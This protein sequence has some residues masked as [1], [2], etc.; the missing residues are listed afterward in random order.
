MQ[1]TQDK[2]FDEHYFEPAKAWAIKFGFEAALSMLVIYDS[3]IHSGRIF[4]FLRSRFQ[5]RP[6]AKGGAETRWIEEYVDARHY[7]LKNHRRPLLR[8]TIYRTE[9]LRREIERNNWDLSDLPIDANG[10]KVEG[11]ILQPAS[12]SARHLHL[13][14]DI[15]PFIGDSGT[16][17]VESSA[18]ETSSP[19][20]E[21]IRDQQLH[22]D[23]R[24]LGS[25]G[26][27]GLAK[28]IQRCLI[29][30]GFLDPPVDG[31]FGPLSKQ[32]LEALR[33]YGSHNDD[34]VVDHK[35]ARLLLETDPDRFCPIQA[36]NDLA[37]RIVRYMQ[38][39]DHF[40]ARLPGYVN[41][42]YL[43]GAD[44]NGNPNQDKP[45]RFNDRRMVLAL[46]NNGSPEI[47][48]NWEATTEPGRHYTYNPMNPKGAA[49]IALGQFKAWSVGWY[50]THYA[51]KQVSELTVYRDLNKDFE[52]SGD[53]RH[54]GLFGIHH[55]WGYDRPVNDIGR[56]S[57][58]CLVGRSTVE[59]NRFMSLV[60]SDPRY[61]VSR[62]YRFMTTIIEASR[63]EGEQA[64]S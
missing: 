9:S 29:G 59:H 30:I 14:S 20:L 32:A 44:R 7:W 55:H 33:E 23:V 15:V 5:E 53:K 1:R 57:A 48:G 16:A 46:N 25:S 13:E 51:L 12:L 40:V 10:V 35:L 47:L 22:M 63:L 26:G 18:A 34:E 37:G 49:R 24:D 4:D 58:G 50:R 56:A 52:R 45:N 39:R 3:F 61:E 31:V 19:N 64:L 11:A 62:G 41:I 6:P 21:Q 42:V 38:E 27:K 54:T 60:Q 36:E 8:K 43:E 2:F 17:S 28:E